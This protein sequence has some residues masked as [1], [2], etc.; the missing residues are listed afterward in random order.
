MTK[1]DQEAHESGKCVG[2]PGCEACER[3]FR[4]N[5]ARGCCNCDQKPTVG[6][7]EL[8]GPCFFGEAETIG[9]NW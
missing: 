9:G 6:D 3:F 2:S 4:K 5:W 7:S 8:C 1:E